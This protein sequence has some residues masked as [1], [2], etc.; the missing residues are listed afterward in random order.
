MLSVTSLT[1][2]LKLDPSVRQNKFDDYIVIYNSIRAIFVLFYCQKYSELVLLQIDITTITS[3]VLNIMKHN[4]T[5]QKMEN[6]F[7]NNIYSDIHDSCMC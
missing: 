4:V 3:P 2:I 5:Y 1:A 6:A 7:H